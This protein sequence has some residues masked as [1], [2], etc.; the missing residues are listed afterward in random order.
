M[1]CN[2]RW[3]LDGMSIPSDRQYQH[4]TSNALKKRQRLKP[5]NQQKDND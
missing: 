3:F 4:L 5:A 2:I 1:T